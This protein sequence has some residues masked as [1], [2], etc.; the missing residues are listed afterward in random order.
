MK[1]EVLCS[2]Q[3]IEALTRGS[4][5]AEVEYFKEFVENRFDIFGNLVASATTESVLE[6]TK[7]SWGFQWGG[8]DNPW[9]GNGNNPWG[10][11]GDNPWGGWNNGNNNN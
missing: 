3:F 7:G 8:G 10:G 4:F 2:K 1:W 11:N 6:E 9:G 5:D